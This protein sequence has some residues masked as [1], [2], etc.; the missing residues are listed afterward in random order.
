MPVSVPLPWRSVWLPRLAALIALIAG[1]PLYLQSPLWCDITLYDLAAQN[2]LHGGTHYR[3][4]FDT[5]LPGFVW[6]LTALRWLFGPSPIVVRVADLAVVIGVMLLIDRLA[7]WG[8]A[9][10]ATRW[11]ALAGAAFIYPFTTEMA[12]AQRD[13]W[14]ALPALAAV[15]LRVQRAIAGKNHGLGFSTSAP[16]ALGK[17]FRESAIEG[18]IWGVAVWLKPHIVIIAAAVWI[19]TYRRLAMRYSQAGRASAMDL[20]GANLAKAGLRLRGFGLA[21]LIESGNLA[22]FLECVDYLESAVCRAVSRRVFVPIFTGI[23]LVPAVELVAA[24]LHSTCTSINRRCQ[25]LVAS[26]RRTG[27]TRTSGF[28]APKLVVGPKGRCRRPFLA[29][30]PGRTVSRLDRSGFFHSA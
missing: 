5:N 14:M 7:K 30:G 10:P 9:T 8:G 16:S 2:L 13:V 1:L 11:W 20:V 24:S 15:V 26:A 6:I 3:D 4:L 23:V 28:E 22:R 27:T 19:L 21:W 29:R 12:H 25:A 18:A 17:I